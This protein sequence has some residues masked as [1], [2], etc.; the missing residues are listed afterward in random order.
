MVRPVSIVPDVDVGG[1]VDVE[2]LGNWFCAKVN[3]TAS[4]VS[5]DRS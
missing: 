5:N 3:K 1:D 4:E 2:E